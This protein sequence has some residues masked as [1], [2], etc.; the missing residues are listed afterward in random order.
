M[1]EVKPMDAF[2]AEGELRRLSS[3][4]LFLLSHTDS[5]SVASTLYINHISKTAENIFVLFV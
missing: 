5:T 3:P 2:V 1:K 4:V